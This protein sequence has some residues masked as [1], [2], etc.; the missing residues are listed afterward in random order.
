MKHN[1]SNIQTE[2]YFAYFLGIANN[3]GA[4]GS[5]IGIDT[6]VVG[7][8]ASVSPG[9]N[10]DEDSAGDQ[11]ATGV[12]LAGILA[13][14]SSADHGAADLA[15]VSVGGGSTLALANDVH[16]HV[17][18]LGGDGA[19]SVGESAP[20]GDGGRS[21]VGG[22][23]ASQT[24]GLDGGAEG[25]GAVD[26]D[27][28]NVVDHGV[29]VVALVVLEGGHREGDTAG[30]PVAGSS[31][32]LQ[33]GSGHGLQTVSGGHD[34]VAGVDGSTAGVASTTLQGDLPGEAADG[35][36]RA[37]DNAAIQLGQESLRDGASQGAGYCRQQDHELQHGA[38]PMS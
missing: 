28:G 31:T 12:T 11:W 16:V 19:G 35:G 5:N 29:G 1:K 18:Q 26:L 33:D 36:S 10:T 15:T 17:L 30:A 2:I 23:G 3:P 22:V 25:Q 4:E 13:A 8:S 9:D 38:N 34:D 21:A 37:A 27:D 20:S 6:G 32:D 24:D 7:V 14:G